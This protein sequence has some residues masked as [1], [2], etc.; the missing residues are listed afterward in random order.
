LPGIKGI[1]SLRSTFDAPFDSLLVQSYVG[2]TRVFGID[3]GCSVV[4]SLWCVWV[5]A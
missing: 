5:P 4:S 2:E 1:W 3:G